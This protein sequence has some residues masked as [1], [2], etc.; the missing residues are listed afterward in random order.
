MSPDRHRR[1]GLGLWVALGLAG[2]LRLHHV[3][4]PLLGTN[5]WRQCDNA[6]VAR[7]FYAHGYRLLWP[8]TDRPGPGSHYVQMEFPAYQFAVALLYRVL[9]IQD[10]LGRWVSLVM[11]LLGTLALYRLALRW[12]DRDAARWAAACFVILPLNAYYGRAFMV[13]S[14][15]LACLLTGVWSFDRWLTERS[16]PAFWLAAVSIALGCLLK[17]VSLYI[18]AVLL[19]LAWIRLGSGWWRRPALWG[20]AALVIVPVTLWYVHSIHLYDATGLTLMG[21]WR[22][23]SD[24]W[25]T[26]GTLT[27]WEWWNRI[28][29]Q[30]LA[31]K[32]LTWFGFAL[33]AAGL[34]MPHRHPTE[35]LLDTWLLAVVAYSMIVAHGAF[36]HEHYQLPFI[37]PAAM[38]IGKAFSR[39]RT[40]GRSRGWVAAARWTLAGAFVMAAVWRYAAMSATEDPDESEPYRLAMHVKAKVEP[41]A[42]VVMVDN[43]DPTDRYHAERQG[44]SV[45]ADEMTIRGD[46]I[47]REKIG[48][49]ARYVAGRYE[50]FTGPGMEEAIHA[51]LVRQHGKVFDD[52]QDFIYRLGRPAVAA[53]RPRPTPGAR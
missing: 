8:E 34:A 10:V 13:E 48:Q 21:D 19:H 52:G 12:L 32:H 38:V 24:K 16:T 2:L 40:T 9:G 44:W 4:A 42:T 28:L 39:A 30:R 47:L 45:H 23:G 14:T 50:L 35:R 17:V 43:D 3:D 46:A 11:S 1:A 27:T 25:G 22:Y 7:N 37:P 26:W 49:G 5:S 36:V 53:S 41:D 33:F 18:G 29:F 51:L 15:M 20:F 31:E 6:I